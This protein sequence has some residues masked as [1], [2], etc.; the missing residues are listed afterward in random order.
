MSGSVGGPG[1]ESVRASGAS[2]SS[3]SQAAHEKA[4]IPDF[5]NRELAN[6]QKEGPKKIPNNWKMIACYAVG[7]VVGLA[8]LTLMLAALAASH[9]TLG[10]VALAVFS[11]MGLSSSLLAIHAAITPV[12]FHGVAATVAS[13]GMSIAQSA[14]LF[15]VVGGVAGAIYTRNKEKA[16]DLLCPES[17]ARIDALAA[18]VL[19]K[20]QSISE[21][22]IAAKE[23]AQK[24]TI[25]SSL[26]GKLCLKTKREQAHK[27][28]LNVVK[29]FAHMM[30][31]GA[32]NTVQA[33]RLGPKHH[34]ATRA[35]YDLEVDLKEKS[36]HLNDRGEKALKE[37]NE[38]RR[39]QLEQAVWSSDAM[40]E[41]YRVAPELS[42]YDRN[43]LKLQVL[44]AHAIVNLHGP[45]RENTLKAIDKELVSQR[46]LRMELVKSRLKPDSQ[47]YKALFDCR[48]AGR[49]SVPEFT[50]SMLTIVD[51]IDQ[52]TDLSP[53]QRGQIVEG[54][55]LLL[56]SNPKA[57]LADINLF[58]YQAYRGFG[59]VTGGVLDRE[60]K[61][62]LI[63][64]EQWKTREAV[65][66]LALQH[67]ADPGSQA[68]DTPVQHTV[69]QERAP[70]LY[71]RDAFFARSRA[72]QVMDMGTSLIHASGLPG[73]GLVG[74]VITGVAVATVKRNSAGA[75]RT[76]TSGLRSQATSKAAAA[77]ASI[78]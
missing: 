52:F 39:D 67:A 71:S 78:Y 7:I 34:A 23:Q 43:I 51:D 72:L 41:A 13:Y 11:K 74:G 68:T 56:N 59:A 35:N 26:L 65:L 14:F 18:K 77:A 27:G 45:E 25:L 19:G 73:S 21:A 24:A 29:G 62:H 44:R 8:I 76:V 4:P 75:A 30:M 49:T 48:Q 57:T 5:V 58:V 60:W 2:D 70:M 1:S 69:S 9:G 10:V 66:N 61:S 3:S 47:E 53:E 28:G 38:L 22:E 63:P 12:L 32:Y 15:L 20:G 54:V 31:S 50:R 16:K 46:L 6:L 64:S 33:L 42:S 36:S 40:A 55:A 17:T 37:L